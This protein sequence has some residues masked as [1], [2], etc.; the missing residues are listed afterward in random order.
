VRYLPGVSD[1]DEALRDVG[2]AFEIIAAVQRRGASAIIED[3]ELTGRLP[4][5]TVALAAAAYAFGERLAEA[6]KA[7][8]DTIFDDLRLQFMLAGG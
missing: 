6:E 1:R 2:L 3:T 7:D 4:Q 5:V 8:L